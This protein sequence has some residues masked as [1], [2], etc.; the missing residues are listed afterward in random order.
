M[1]LGT[2][3]AGLGRF[4]MTFD[5]PFAGAMFVIFIQSQQAFLLE[6]EFTTDVP[7]IQQ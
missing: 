6:L 4:C 7:K 5:A 2:A 1:P 3:T